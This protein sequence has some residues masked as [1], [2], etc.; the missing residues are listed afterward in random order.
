MHFSNFKLRLPDS[1]PRRGYY[2]SPLCSQYQIISFPL[3]PK[4]IAIIVN[5]TGGNDV[6][7]F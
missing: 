1:D 2:G 5:L 4:A 7:L 6:S 3:S